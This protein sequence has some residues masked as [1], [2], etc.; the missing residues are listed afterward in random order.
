[1]LAAD[2]FWMDEHPVT[3]AAFRRFV[4]E[5][6]YVTVAERSLDPADYPDT[7]P[8]LLGPGSLVFRKTTGPV[9]LGEYRNWWVYV[10]G[11]YWKRPSG[12]AGTIN[13]RDHHPAVHVAYEDVETYANGAG[14][15]L[16]SEA[17]WNSPR[18][19]DS[20]VPSSPV[21]TSISREASRRPTHGRESFP[22]RA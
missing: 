20:T 15:T 6:G 13:G 21:A 8:A 7:D 16:P 5:T 17:E 11:A 3:V 14:K 1:M 18:G 4:G 12:P 9:D 2:G 19:A 22:G 10:L